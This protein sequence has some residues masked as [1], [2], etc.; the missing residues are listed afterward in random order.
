MEFLRLKELLNNNVCRVIFTK[1]SGKDRNMLCTL[2]D[3]YLPEQYHSGKNNDQNSD[4]YLCVWDI[5]VNGIRSF[6][7]DSIKQF[8]VVPGE[9]A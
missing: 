2:S 9:M 5:E 6:R 7:L 4:E 3:F 1:A 8:T